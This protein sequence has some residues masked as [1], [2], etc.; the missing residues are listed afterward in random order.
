MVTSLMTAGL[1]V[2]SRASSCPCW[3]QEEDTANKIGSVAIK[4]K[5][6]KPQKK[7]QDMKSPVKI[8]SLCPVQGFAP[9]AA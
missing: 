2:L 8:T 3:H 9:Q 1:D 4:K 7:R 5:Q 6:V